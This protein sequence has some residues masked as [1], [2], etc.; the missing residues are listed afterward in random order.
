MFIF[1]SNEI[2]IRLT[3]ELLAKIFKKI[4]NYFPKSYIIT[5]TGNPIDI[6]GGATANDYKFIIEQFYDEKNVNRQK[7]IM[8]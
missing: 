8:Q 4:S 3:V 2:N 1:R 6:T 5:K 7:S